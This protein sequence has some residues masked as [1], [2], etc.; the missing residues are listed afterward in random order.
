MQTESTEFEN[1]AIHLLFQNDCFK[2]RFSLESKGRSHSQVY[3]KVI[4]LRLKC[5]WLGFKVAGWR[6]RLILQTQTC[7]T[8]LFASNLSFHC[9]FQISFAFPH[10]QTWG[11][12]DLTK[13]IQVLEQHEGEKCFVLFCFLRFKKGNATE[14]E[15]KKLLKK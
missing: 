4:S 13:I 8:S 3:V 7:F 11:Y 12:S 14:I 15:K 5:H 1:G 6:H 9:S 10:I 2:I